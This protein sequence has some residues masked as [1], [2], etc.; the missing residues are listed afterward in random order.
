MARPSLIIITPHRLEV[1]QD[2]SNKVQV[3]VQ[4]FAP[5]DCLVKVTLPEQATSFEFKSPEGTEEESES[6]EVEQIREITHSFSPENL[7]AW[8]EVEIPF[9]L[10]TNNPSDE[11]ILLN[12]I[13]EAQNGSGE[14]NL[15]DQQL[16]LIFHSQPADMLL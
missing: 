12:L 16:N 11:Q 2:T 3:K 9:V 6:G 15:G 7:F 5:G 14:T 10:H 8:T 1:H 4:A 13:F